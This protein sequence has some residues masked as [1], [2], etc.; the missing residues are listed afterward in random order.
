MSHRNPIA[1][2]GSLSKCSDTCIC[3]ET[4][5][6]LTHASLT[7]E[8]HVFKQYPRA[9]PISAAHLGPIIIPFTFQASTSR[10]KWCELVVRGCEFI[11]RERSTQ[12]HAN[13]KTRASSNSKDA[14]V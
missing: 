5:V 7:R 6:R 11:S 12:T 1:R 2:T 10:Y 13:C 14:R 9:H 3:R 4:C 8:M